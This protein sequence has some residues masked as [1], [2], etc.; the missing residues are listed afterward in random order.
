MPLP[1][2][3]DGVFEKPEESSLALEENKFS[4]PEIT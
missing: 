4:S 1:E 3:H 2:F